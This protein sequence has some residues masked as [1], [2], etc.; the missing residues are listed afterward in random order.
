VIAQEIRRLADQTAVSTLDIER[1]VE[2]M[3]GVVERGVGEIGHF[4]EQTRSGVS[5][6]ER[7]GRELERIIAQVEALSPRFAVVR[8]GMAA[9][10]RGAA[11]ITDA[12]GTLEASAA[13]TGR[14]LEA[15]S[16]VAEELS[17]AVAE[18]DLEVSRFRV[19][20]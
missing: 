5:A 1:M 2:E 6:A 7:I 20:G 11:M 14:A 15:F 18:L 12:V 3:H 9:Q 4:V 17:V 10:E 8:S 19:Q 16:R 13:A